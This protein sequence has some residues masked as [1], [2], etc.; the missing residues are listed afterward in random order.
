MMRY[1]LK[2]I[3]RS[4]KKQPA[5]YF[6]NISGLAVGITGI[7]FILIY[8][9]NEISFDRYHTNSDRIYRVCQKYVTNNTG[10]NSAS[11]PFPASDALR[12]YFTGK[13]E[14]TVRFYN[15]QSAKHLIEYE[16]QKHIIS[17][18]FFVDSTIFD[19]FDVNFIK[20]K[21]N[22]PLN[23]PYKA[24]ISSSLAQKV[25]ANGEPLGKKIMLEGGIE[26]EISGVF[27]DIPL[28]SHIRYDLLASF[29]TLDAL[30]QGKKVQ[31]WVYNP[32]WTYV[33]L[34]KDTDPS[35]LEDEFPAFIN[36][37]YFDAQKDSISLYLQKLTDIH[38]H[39]DLDYEIN[40]NGN[41]NNLRILGGI[42]LF[43][44]I[45]ISINYINLSTAVA[46]K[47]LREIGVKKVYGANQKQIIVQFVSEAILLT[48]LAAIFALML[49]EII[50]PYFQNFAHIDY[51]Y[52]DLFH[53]KALAVLIFIIFILGIASGIYPAFY[54]AKFNPVKILKGDLKNNVRVVSGR[55]I[56]LLLQFTIS[57]TMI[58]VTIVIFSQLSFMRK[59]DVG[60]AKDNII[61]IDINR[62]NIVREYE[63]FK[64][65]LLKFSGIMNVTVMDYIPGTGYN[66]HEYWYDGVK[67]SN[68]MY[69]PSIIVEDDFVETF[70]IEIVAGRNYIDGQ[71][72]EDSLSILVNESLLKSLGWTHQEAIGKKFKS[73]LGDEQIVGV[74]KDFYA[75]SLHSKKTPLVLN[76][77]E[78]DRERHF[79]RNF[80][81]I[82]ID[83]SFSM[84]NS[85][86]RFN[87]F[88]LS[89]MKIM[90]SEIQE[91]ISYVRTVWNDFTNSRPFNYTFLSDMLDQQY[92]NEARLGGLSIVFTILT[93]L[94][95][96]MGL[97]GLSLFNSRQ[98]I[99][100]LGIR[101][102]M[103]AGF[104]NI[105]KLLTKD[106][107]VLVSSAAIIAWGV[108][109]L[110]I[111]TWFQN[112]SLTVEINYFV[113]LLAYLISLVLVLLIS[114]Y[115][116]YQVFKANAAH[117]LKY[118]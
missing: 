57:I 63:Q 92:Q 55:K 58:I 80:V 82:E 112:Y 29:S 36:E 31:S 39:S 77:K 37:Y 18:F 23:T 41:A 33:L 67:K 98:R 26:L 3:I 116:S 103:G 118:E 7:V 64:D 70:D 95:S 72:S 61:I 46:G 73:L 84:S 17:D 25:F 2:Y 90:S 43:I 5:Y 81:A 13:I 94:I 1:L 66:V 75:K 74:F 6:I 34:E 107:F 93:I 52:A 105:M 48:S 16:Q 28:Q 24:V 11:L 56:L 101:M 110:F 91:I 30:R 9:L 78:R 40:A 117:I 99:K 44:L 109:Y 50:F 69:F 12:S 10:E 83:P 111:V 60:F 45:T 102:V 89:D 14:E 100:E 79:F 113:F 62:S 47:R 59:A 35:V 32:C 87:N 15:S 104:W 20:S 85:K 88:F 8:I 19:V 97:V 42:A 115:R 54:V 49:I 108:S 51:E 27:E 96:I 106:F 76:M 22:N 114:T 65:E 21:G 53:G 4:V 71:K 68:W 38:L 86:G